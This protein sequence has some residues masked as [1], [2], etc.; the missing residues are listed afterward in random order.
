MVES[1]YT[2]VFANQAFDNQSTRL[3]LQ[4]SDG[5]NHGEAMVWSQSVVMLSVDAAH[6]V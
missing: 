4:K 3:W 2:K 5:C 1:I 6:C